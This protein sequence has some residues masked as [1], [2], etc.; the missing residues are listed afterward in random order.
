[1]TQQTQRETAEPHAGKELGSTEFAVT[2]EVM[3]NYFE[4]LELDPDGC[5]ERSPLGRP[6]APSMIVT[7]ADNS[8]T[9]RGGFSNAFGNLWMRQQ[10]KLHQ[11]LTQGESYRC[12]GRI[13]DIYEKRD[14][15]VVDTET[16]VL[17]PDG[18]VM[19]RGRHYQSYLLGRPRVRCSC[20]TRT[21][22]RVHAALTSPAAS[23][24]S[25][26]TARSR[27]RCAARSSTARRTNTPTRGPRRIWAS[28]TSSW[29]G[30]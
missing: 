7:A 24:S 26:W 20:G 10:W 18:E 14:R 21:P 4:G 1:M 27:W 9:G 16:T 22:R 5:G 13:V 19:A 6:V 23:R 28:G 30:G 12:S 29:A 25:R 2:D 8:F 3:A 17:G 15:T 11:P